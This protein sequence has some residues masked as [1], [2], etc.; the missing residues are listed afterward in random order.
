MGVEGAKRL[1]RSF[2]G[3]GVER[4]KLGKGSAWN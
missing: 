4:F 3:R 1:G 2:E